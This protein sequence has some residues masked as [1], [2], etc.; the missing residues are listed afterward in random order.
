MRIEVGTPS[1]STPALPKFF[2]TTFRE[3]KNGEKTTLSG[4]ESNTGYNYKTFVF[5]NEDEATQFAGKEAL[6]QM[7]VQGIKVVI[8]QLSGQV[9]LPIKPE[10][11]Q[12]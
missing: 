3:I 9:V 11:R 8:G 6:R 1:P 12:L 4:V 5:D 7:N 10:I 2:V